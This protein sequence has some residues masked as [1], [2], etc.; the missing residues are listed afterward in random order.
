M[1]WDYDALSTISQETNAI[2]KNINIE[3]WRIILRKTMYKFWIMGLK[4]HNI[5]K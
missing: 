4:Q 1:I 3:S 5:I 2:I